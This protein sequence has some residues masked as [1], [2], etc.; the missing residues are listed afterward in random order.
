MSLYNKIAKNQ[1]CVELV[2]K[3]RAIKKEKCPAIVFS[4]TIIALLSA[5]K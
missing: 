5:N 1:K 4:A 2:R 3:A